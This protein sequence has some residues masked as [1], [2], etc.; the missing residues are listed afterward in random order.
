MCIDGQIFEIPLAFTDIIL[1][2]G[3]VPMVLGTSGRYGH[4]ETMI[5]QQMCI[6]DK[7]F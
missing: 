6:N 2:G 1:R 7:M 3:Y 5:V 4:E